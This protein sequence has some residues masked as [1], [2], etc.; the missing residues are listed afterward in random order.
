MHAWVSAD[1]YAAQAFVAYGSGELQTAGEYF[2]KSLQRSS[3]EAFYHRIYLTSLGLGTVAM[4]LNK[5]GDARLH[6][7]KYLPLMKKYRLV[8]EQIIINLLLGTGIPVT[9][10]MIRMP[11]INLLHMIQKA[12]QTG[13][14]SDYRKAYTYA[15]SKSLLGLLHRWIVFF[16]DIVLH[17]IEKGKRTG[18]PKLILTYPV[19]SEKRP[20]FH[21]TFFGQV[22]ISRNQR[23]LRAKLSPQE[24]AVWIHLALRAGEPGGFIPLADL[25]DNFWS[26]GKQPAGRLSHILVSLKNNLKIPSHL[27]GIVS[28]Q[29]EPRLVNRGLYL[30]T[31][32]KEIETLLTQTKILTRAN[33][34]QFARRDYIRAFNLI[35]GEPFRKMYD[36]WS[37]QMRGV[38]FNKIQQA[39]KDFTRGCLEH[40]SKSDAERVISRLAS[41]LPDSVEIKKLQTEL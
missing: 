40:G 38:I 10:D 5:K 8:K 23:R 22:T 34:W 31:D 24:N 32:Y 33:E 20:V 15:K 13:R 36:P 27:I 30:T 18:L 9:E 17:M 41:T 14:I 3:R 11:D 21:T 4:A 29:G 26:R 7:K 35:R 16:P 25:Y 19:F 12:N 6:L 37:E 1:Y 39:T 28:R 2:L